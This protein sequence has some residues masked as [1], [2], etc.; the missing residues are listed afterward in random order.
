MID[1]CMLSEAEKSEMHKK[2]GVEEGV[3]G[4]YRVQL[5][6]CKI[7][8]IRP[9]QRGMLLGMSRMGMEGL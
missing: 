9:T 7:C 2:G 5:R 3:S 4:T 1:G 6:I 8:F